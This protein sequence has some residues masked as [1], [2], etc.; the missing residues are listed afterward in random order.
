MIAVSFSKTVKLPDISQEVIEACEKVQHFISLSPLRYDRRKKDE[1][2]NLW[3]DIPL[4][5]PCSMKPI[6][7]YVT[8][9]IIDSLLFL[10]A[11]LIGNF[12][13][14]PLVKLNG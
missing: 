1:A 8:S 9:M 3:K 7:M 4:Q 2:V 12:P 10:Q 14:F 5:A 11:D 13:S 6:A